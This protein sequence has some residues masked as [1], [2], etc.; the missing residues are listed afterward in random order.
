MKWIKSNLNNF[1]AMLFQKQ[2]W[3]S[4]T[5]EHYKPIRVPQ[6]CPKI[7][8]YH[9]TSKGNMTHRRYDSSRHNTCSA[10][11]DWIWITFFH[12][13]ITDN[14]HSL[15]CRQLHTWC[16][17]QWQVYERNRYVTGS[18]DELALFKLPLPYPLTDRNRRARRCS[19]T[20]VY[21][22]G[23]SVQVVW[24]ESTWVFRTLLSHSL[25]RLIPP[26]IGGLS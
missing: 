16:T 8:T 21:S 26:F 5:G 20:Y 17:M 23:T 12:R 10:S 14:V 24:N 22:C 13:N 3:F 4:L 18:S 7:S 9:T 6:F 25:I 1:H 2:N 15:K 11:H 19:I